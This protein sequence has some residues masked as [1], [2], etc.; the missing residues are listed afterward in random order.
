MRLRF[1]IEGEPLQSAG[2]AITARRGCDRSPVDP[3]SEDGR[4]TLL[5]Y[6]WPDQVHRVARTRA[7]LDLAAKVPV[8]VDRAGAADWI[9]MQLAQRREGVATVVFHSIVMQYL[10]EGERREFAALMKESGERADADAPLAWLRME[11]AGE[12]AEVR[13]TIWPDGEDRVI[14]HASYHGDLVDLHRAV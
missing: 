8:A 3:T 2:V 10:E 12:Q 4:L 13:L 6:L 14:A 9:G 11:P 5:S 7:A 1:Q